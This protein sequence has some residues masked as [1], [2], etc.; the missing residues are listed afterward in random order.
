MVTLSFLSMD[1]QPIAF[2]FFL[3]VPPPPDFSPFPLPAPLP[4]PPP[5][6]R[7]PAHPKESRRGARVSRENFFSSPPAPRRRKY[8]DSGPRRTSGNADSLAC[9]VLSPE[10]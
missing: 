9:R 3:N 4:T 1:L 5:R 10:K 7:K 8:V 6:A 2:F